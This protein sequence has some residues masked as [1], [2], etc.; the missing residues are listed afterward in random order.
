LYMVILE[1][2]TIVFYNEH[3]IAVTNGNINISR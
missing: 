1:A 3:N 2:D